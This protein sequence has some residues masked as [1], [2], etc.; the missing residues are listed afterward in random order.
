MCILMESKFIQRNKRLATDVTAVGH[1]TLMLFDVLQK[2]V[3]FFKYLATFS[4]GTFKDLIKK[5]IIN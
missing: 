4:H 3:Q 5:T 2:T 1:L